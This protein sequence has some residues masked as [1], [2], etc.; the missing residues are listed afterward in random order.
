MDVIAQMIVQAKDTAG[1]LVDPTVEGIYKAAILSW[2]QCHMT[3]KGKQP[4]QANKIST[5]K[6]KGKESIFQSQQ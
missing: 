4:V 1:K 5:I 6:P 2:G 3:G